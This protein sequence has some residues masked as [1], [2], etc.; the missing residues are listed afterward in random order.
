MLP[1]VAL[2]LGAT[3]L[4]LGVFS[5]SLPEADDRFDP[6]SVRM[7]ATQRRAGAWMWKIG[8]IVAAAGMLG[9]I[10]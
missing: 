9:L 5:S 8:A 2:V 3:L 1:Q 6:Y 7:R 4:V 10:L